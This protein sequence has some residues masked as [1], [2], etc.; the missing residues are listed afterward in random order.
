MLAFTPMHLE[1]LVEAFNAW[2]PNEGQDPKSCFLLATGSPPPAFQ[3]MFMALIFYDGPEEEGRRH[4]KK[5]FDLGPVVD[6]TDSHPY[7]VQVPTLLDL[8][9]QLY[10]EA[11]VSGVPLFWGKY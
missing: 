1:P 10:Q 2:W 6:M 8:F 11:F 3:P 4:F 9:L 5:F 7:V